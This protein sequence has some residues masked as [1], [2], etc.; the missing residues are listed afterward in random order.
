MQHGSPTISQ[1]SVAS[2]TEGRLGNDDEIKH[3]EV[4]S[5]ARLHPGVEACVSGGTSAGDDWDQAEILV[6]ALGGQTV[7]GRGSLDWC[8]SCGAHVLH[9]D[10]EVG[11]AVESL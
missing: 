2:V 9:E 3:P 5:S 1:S 7:E 6:V 10:M 11:A 4:S 8:W